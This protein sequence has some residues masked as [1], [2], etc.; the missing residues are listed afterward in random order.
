MALTLS[1][2]QTQRDEAVRR[3]GEIRVSKG[4]A[5]VEYAE[6]TKTVAFLDGEIAKLSAVSGGSK[7]LRR[8][9]I[10]TNKGF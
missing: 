2:L 6:V 9:V 1:E 3:A 7:P 8:T 4:D 10:T 5:S